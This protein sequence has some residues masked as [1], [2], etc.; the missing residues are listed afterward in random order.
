[1]KEDIPKEI[2]SVQRF[3]EALDWIYSILVREIE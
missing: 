1:M 2:N 3:F